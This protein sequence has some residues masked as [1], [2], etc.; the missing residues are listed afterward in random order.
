MST[1][2]SFLR[3]EDEIE[4]FFRQSE[5]VKFDFAAVMNWQLPQLLAVQRFTDYCLCA[6]YDT[7]Y[8]EYFH[9]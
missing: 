2:S 7:V 4:Q 8:E 1:K 9:L 3:K 5:G 6:K